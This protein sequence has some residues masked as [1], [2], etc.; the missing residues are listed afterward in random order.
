MSVQPNSLHSRVRVDVNKELSQARLWHY[1][2]LPTDRWIS[3]WFRRVTRTHS[4]GLLWPF[5]LW[6][7]AGKKQPR[8]CR[9]PTATNCRQR[10]T[11]N[12]KSRPSDKN[13]NVFNNKAVCAPLCCQ[14]YLCC[15][16]R[17]FIST[18]RIKSANLVC[19]RPELASSGL[20]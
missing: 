4:E 13:L 1:R 17:G 6:R 20:D 7:S 19:I 14:G 3:G 5:I 11:C 10:Q 16:R 18:E 9:N 12:L 8:V 15:S 2:P